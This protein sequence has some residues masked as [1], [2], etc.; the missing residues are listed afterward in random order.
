MLFHVRFVVRFAVRKLAR[1]NKYKTSNK[2]KRVFE[3]ERTD[4][5][6]NVHRLFATNYNV[7][8]S[9]YIEVRNFIIVK[10][11]ASDNFRFSNSCIS[12]GV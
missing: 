1:V 2:R 8:I 7:L 12:R 3:N 6:H 5:V 11:E 9:V 10:Y 4:R